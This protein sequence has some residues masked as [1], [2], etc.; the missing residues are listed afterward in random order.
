M[1]QPNTKTDEMVERILDINQKYGI[2]LIAKNRITSTISQVRKESYE[3][4]RRD[5]VKDLE[6]ISE[7]LCELDWK[8]I[9]G[10]YLTHPSEEA[11]GK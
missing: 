9:K 1:T 11:N 6:Q 3:Q 7:D 4:G 8:R 2:G 10:H 5:V